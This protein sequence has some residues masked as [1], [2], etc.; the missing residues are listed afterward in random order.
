MLVVIAYRDAIILLRHPFSFAAFPVGW[1]GYEFLLSVISPHGSAGSIA[2]TQADLLPLVQISSLTGVFGVTFILT[3]VPAGLAAMFHHRENKKFAFIALATALIVSLGSMTY[4]WVRL[5]TP[6]TG[7]SVPV[8][9][10][11]IDTTVRDTY[12]TDREKALRVLRAYVRVV[13]PLADRGAKIVVL[14]EK[15]VCI[16]SDYETDALNILTGAA[17]EGKLFIVAGLNR[18]GTQ[19]HRNMA[20]LI[21]PDG[22]VLAEYD[23]VYPIPGLESEYRRGTKMLEFQILN[24]I[25]GIAICK[26]LDFPRSI[27]QYGETGIGV[28]FVPAWDFT[29]DAWLHCRMAVVRGVENGFA[30]VR[31]ANEGFLT[32]SDDRGRILAQR[33]AATVRFASLLATAPVHHDDTLY[34]RWGDWFAWLNVAGLIALVLS[35]GKLK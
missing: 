33:D 28:L 25:G 31:S 34:T 3:L 13:L 27:R 1:T 35:R 21:G 16:T 12:T 18:L 2:Y 23:K 26:D 32:V 10:A 20:I 7:F 22:T 15:M 4:G 11:A 8:G 17:K 5:A 9:L 19:P 30:M 24:F 14:P 29:V 6:A